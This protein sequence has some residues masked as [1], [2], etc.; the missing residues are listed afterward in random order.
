MEEDQ[1]QVRHGGRHQ[2]TPGFWVVQDVQARNDKNKGGKRHQGGWHGKVQQQNSS[3]DDFHQFNCGHDKAC[4][5]ARVHKGIDLGI[6][7]WNLHPVEEA[8]QAPE[9]HLQPKN[10]PADNLD[11]FNH[12]VSVAEGPG[13]I[14]AGF[15]HDSYHWTSPNL[16]LP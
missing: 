8:V 1:K 14:N 2:N 11:V 6:R 4:F 3:T 7:G 16:Q 15:L 13:Q 10:P 5:N 12:A 9:K